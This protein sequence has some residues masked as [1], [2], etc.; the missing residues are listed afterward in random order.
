[1]KAVYRDRQREK[2]GHSQVRGFKCNGAIGVR[3]DVYQKLTRR[4][5]LRAIGAVC[6]TTLAATVGAATVDDHADYATRVKN[7]TENSQVRLLLLSN[8]NLSGKYL[9]YA[10][11]WIQEHFGASTASTKTVL[12][13]PYATAVK[14]W[15]SYAKKVA[16]TLAPLG[17]NAVSAHSSTDPRSLLE[18]ADGVFVGGGNTFRLLH[19]L[20]TTGMTSAIRD[21]AHAGMPYLGSSAGTNVA[22]R[23]IKTTNDMP[24]VFPQSL[25]AMSLVPF[26][27]N[28]H[29]VDGGFSYTAQGKTVPYNG[30]TRAERIKEF[31]EEN[32]APVI[33]LREGTALRVMR[34]RIEI[35][36]DKPAKV[37]EKCKEPVDV[38][39]GE[40]LSH[41]LSLDG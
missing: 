33:G 14:Q 8:S 12:F 19:F 36:G 29:Y 21:R 5:L 30:E 11:S 6:G 39:D 17:I 18:T 23:T 26:Q 3:M 15:D 9:E 32:D 41:L 2:L 7:M 13:V 16:R 24:I 38:T 27:I 4:D 20:Q 1:M 35:L 28:V 10:F 37:F 22:A 40:V 34:G 31:H 25:D